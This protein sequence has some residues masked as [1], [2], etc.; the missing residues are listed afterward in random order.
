VFVF[1]IVIRVE[2]SPATGGVRGKWVGIGGR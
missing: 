2:G 1:L